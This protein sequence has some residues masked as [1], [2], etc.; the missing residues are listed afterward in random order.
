MTQRGRVLAA[1]LALCALALVARL[2]QLQVFQHGLWKAAAAAAQERTIEISP[3]RGTI[4]DRS[5][6]ALAFDVKAMAIAV[7]SFNMTKPATLITILSEELGMQTSTLEDLVYRQSYFTWIDR[8]VD[9]EVSRRIESRAKEAGAWGLITLDTWKRCYPEGRLASNLIGFVGADG[10]GLEGLELLFDEALRGHPSQVHVLEGAD[11]RTYRTEVVNEGEPGADLV[12]TIDA[13]L[14]FVCEEEI[15][16]GVA[17]LR[18]QAG[19]VVVLDPETG[20]VLA[21]AQDKGYDLNRFWTSTPAQRRN[22]AVTYMF[23]PGSIFKVFAGLAALQAGT[24]AVT[25]TFDGDDGIEIGGHVMH[26]ADNWSYGTVTFAEVIQDSINT[27][28]IQVAL[29]LGAEPLRDTLA[30][31]GFGAATE[32]D[33]PGEVDGILRR[34]D[35]WTPLDLAASSIGQSVGVTGIQLVRGLA[36]VANDGW[37]VAPHV[38]QSIGGQLSVAPGDPVPGLSADVCR[39]MRS[40][41]VRVVEEGTGTRAALDGFTVAGKTGT[42]QKAV[43]GRG[44]V[45]EKYTSLFAGMFPAEAPELVILVALDEVG[46]SNVGGGSTAAPIFQKVASRLARLEHMIPTGAGL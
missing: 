4:Y 38:V 35:A 15:E 8:A 43:P 9:L 5:G 37:L 26:N 30:N 40:L 22:L 27:G 25:D 10:E 33:L 44:Y 11:G 31:L 2:V 21:M 3:R 42:A 18:A 19:M 14:Q 24:V 7:D 6:Q 46:M 1:I 34:A 45:D 13:Q 41:M 17:D 20:E 12:L 23:E 28:M 32:I 39:T 29:D 16:Q 36:A